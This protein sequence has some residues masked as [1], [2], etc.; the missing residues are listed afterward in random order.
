LIEHG[1][2][3]EALEEDD[4]IDGELVPLLYVVVKPMAL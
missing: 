2:C 1:D 3:D 4:T